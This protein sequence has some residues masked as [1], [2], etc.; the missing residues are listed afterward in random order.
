MV[1][2]KI[3]QSSVP[4]GA[5]FCASFI[6][7]GWTIKHP[8]PMFHNTLSVTTYCPLATG[9]LITPAAQPTRTRLGY[10]CVR[11]CLNG[12]YVAQTL[13][14]LQC[15]KSQLY[16]CRTYRQVSNYLATCK[17]KPLFPVSW[18]LFFKAPTEAY[19]ESRLSNITS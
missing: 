10:L 9:F 15:R 7:S 2:H 13:G 6:N 1:T 19:S 17:H 16:K 18:P 11:P 14:I 12:K 5:I 8:W 4:E 3:S